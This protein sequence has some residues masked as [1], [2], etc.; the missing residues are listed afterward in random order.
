MSTVFQGGSL[1]PHLTVEKNILFGRNH[2]H[3]GSTAFSAIVDQFN[4]GD[5]LTRKP[6]TLSGGQRQRVA[7]ARAFL[8]PSQILLLD[9]PTTFLDSES[10]LEIR[11]HMKHFFSSYE[12]IVLLVSHDK[13]DIRELATDVAT[14]ALQQT[15]TTSATLTF[16]Q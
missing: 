9:E 11:H 16:A 14:I 6:S 5:F 1:L 3:S 7:L 13:D 2:I 4:L 15:Q 12:G 8:A 10:R